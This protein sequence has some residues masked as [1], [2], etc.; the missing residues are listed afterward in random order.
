MALQVE[1]A[2]IGSWRLVL[3]LWFEP[4]AKEN[5]ILPRPQVSAVCRFMEANWVSKF[6]LAFVVL[7]SCSSYYNVLF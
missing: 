3:A 6:Q 1:G 5:S 2:S 7:C 4:R